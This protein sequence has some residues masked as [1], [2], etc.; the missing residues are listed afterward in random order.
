MH[1]FSVDVLLRVADIRG[2]FSA[3]FPRFSSLRRFL[4]PEDLR[5]PLQ[6]FAGTGNVSVPPA[7]MYYKWLPLT[8]WRGRDHVYS[9]ITPTSMEVSGSFIL[10][11][12]RL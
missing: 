11:S 10:H 7:F 4:A 2:R 3:S 1:N 12:V 9:Y 6:Q 8:D 5:E